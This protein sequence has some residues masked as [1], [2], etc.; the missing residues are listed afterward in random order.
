MALHDALTGLPNRT[1]L[2]DRLAHAIA[3]ASRD[4]KHLAVLMLDLDRFNSLNDSLGY[5][6]GDRALESVA[7]KLKSTLR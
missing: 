2:E 4:Q 7:R 3:Q 6:A 5:Y 1:L